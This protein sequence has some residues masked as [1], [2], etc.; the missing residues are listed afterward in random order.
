LTEQSYHAA[1]IA[2]GIRNDGYDYVTIRTVRQ[3]F[4][5]DVEP[6]H[7]NNI[8][9]AMTLQNNQEAGIALG[10]VPHPLTP[11]IHLNRLLLIRPGRIISFA[12]T[13]FANDV[14]VWL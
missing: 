10:R 7:R 6:Q 11:H 5:Y 4:D 12:T 2:A 1:S 8:V 13:V 3:D 14:G 9:E